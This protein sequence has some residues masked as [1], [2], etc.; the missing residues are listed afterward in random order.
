MQLVGIR[1]RTD[2]GCFRKYCCQRFAR[3][4]FEMGFTQMIVQQKSLMPFDTSFGET[5]HTNLGYRVD[6]YTL[7]GVP[8]G[9]N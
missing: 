9:T 5:D 1:N 8:T 4:S 3:V 7:S 2:M 6:V